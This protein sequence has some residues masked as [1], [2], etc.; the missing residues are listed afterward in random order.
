MGQEKKRGKVGEGGR[1]IRFLGWSR[2]NGRKY[3]IK[4]NNI[5]ILILIIIVIRDK[6]S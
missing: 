5:I 1:E 4:K 3:M 6:G 2:R